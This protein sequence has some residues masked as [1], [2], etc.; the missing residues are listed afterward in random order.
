MQ[1]PPPPHRFRLSAQQAVAVQRALAGSVR[2]R[3]LPGVRRVLGLDCAFEPDS[4]LAVGVVWDL[5]Q[6]LVIETRGARAPLT[7]PYVPGLLSFRE[8]PAL[9]K[10]MRR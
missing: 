6:R 3:P 8:L 1:I 9:L 7:F 2:L 4:V 10:V 5:A